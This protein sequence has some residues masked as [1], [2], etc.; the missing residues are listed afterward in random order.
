M[1]SNLILAAYAA[2]GGAIGSVLR[3][4]VGVRFPSAPGALPFETL[5]VNVTGSILI[6]LLMP[7]LATRPE[8]RAFLVIGICGGYTT[9]SAFSLETV[10]LIQSGRIGLALLYMLL[11]LALCAA[12]TW[13][14]LVL[15]R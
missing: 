11:S 8:G 14:G 2:A 12:G 13:L 3:F 4:A 1:S 15:G 7:A 9:F 6:G 10:T 5:L